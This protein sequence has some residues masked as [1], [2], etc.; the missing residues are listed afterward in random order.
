MRYLRVWNSPLVTSLCLAIVSERR[1][2]SESKRQTMGFFIDTGLSLI[3]TSEGKFL[4]ESNRQVLWYHIVL[5]LNMKKKKT[6][7]KNIITL[8]VRLIR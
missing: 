5:Q 8:I 4:I 2:L 7:S 3:V 1:N 6:L